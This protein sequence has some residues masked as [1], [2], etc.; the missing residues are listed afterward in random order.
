[1]KTLTLNN[2]RT[3]AYG[4]YGD[5]NGTP[6]VYCHG[7]S[8]SRMIKNSDEALTQSLGVKIIAVDQPG[9]GGSTAQRGRTLKNWAEDIEQLADC[10]QLEK[11]AVAGHSGGG[12]HAFALAAFLRERVTHGVLAAPMGPMDLPNMSKLSSKAG[13]FLIRL[14]KFARFFRWAMQLVAWWSKKDI[15]RYVVTVAKADST[16][17]NTDTFL[18][19]EKQRQMFKSNY[20]TGF[21]QGAEGLIGM[22]EALGNWAFTLADVPQHFDIFI[23][24]NDTA[25]TPA[26]AKAIVEQLPNADFH[27]WET[28]GHYCF[29]DNLPNR[30]HWRDFLTAIKR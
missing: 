2:G 13:Y 29:V 7:L 27:L 20:E 9:V 24:A 14:V 3:L 30:P 22:F 25:F 26:M 12:P 5:P 11:F 1:M 28:G 10:L 18:A 4:I 6:V 17:G 23:G 21:E 19:D 15:D 8:D 16:D